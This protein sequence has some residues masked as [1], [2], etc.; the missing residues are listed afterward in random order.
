[1][2][3]ALWVP[4]FDELADPLL[5]ARLAAEAEERG[6]HGVFV[7]DHLAWRPPVRAVADPWITLAAAATATERVLLGP[8]VT[9]LPRRRPTKLARET[10]TLD[11]LSGGRLVLGV[12]LGSDR[13]GREFSATGD[14]VDDRRRGAMLDEA[15][16]RP[17]RGLVGRPVRH[18]GE[19]YV[20]DD[21]TFLP[22][23]AHRIPVWV[24]GFPGSARPRRRAATRDGFFPVNLEHPDQLAAADR[25]PGPARHRGGPPRGHRRHRVRRRRRDLVAHRLRPGE[26]HRGP[27]ARRAAGRPG[28]K[29]RLVQANGVELGVQTFGSPAD[30]TV[31]LIHG[32]CASMLWWPEELCHLL[33]DRGLHVVRFDSRDTGRSTHYPAGAP[34]YGLRDLADDAVGLL[35]ALGIPVAH[36]VG[37][38]MGGGTAIIAALD[39]PDRVATLTLVGTTNGDPTCPPCPPRWP[40]RS[41]GR[42]PAIRSP[43][44]WRRSGPTRARR[45]TSTKPPPARP[46]P[47][48]SPGPSTWPPR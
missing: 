4:L 37:R 19:H 2:R 7:W 40:R 27:G 14:E 11:L 47:P 20:V 34:P 8:M 30:P 29:E 9:P 38:S 32:A 35:D 21:L 46:R 10:A 24:A 33:A 36:L 43:T 48:M 6:W 26:D 39:H 28:V 22:R 41:N 17:R 5:V 31:L 25:R 3:S 12:G 15:L 13:F 18:R 44:S 16:D 45:R 1:M 42:R 23:P